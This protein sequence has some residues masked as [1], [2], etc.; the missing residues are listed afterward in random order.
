MFYSGQCG[1]KSFIN[2]TCRSK[3][4]MKKTIIFFSNYEANNTMHFALSFFCCHTKPL[5][6][7]S[8]K[9]FWTYVWMKDEDADALNDY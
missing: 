5:I 1:E 3:L 6:A 7:Q 9:G 4:S 8:V 2:I